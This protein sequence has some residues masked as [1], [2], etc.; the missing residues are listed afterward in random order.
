[1][2]AQRVAPAPPK[3]GGSRIMVSLGRTHAEIK[4]TSRQADR[5]PPGPPG[6]LP[7]ELTKPPR[8][9]GAPPGNANSILDRSAS[10]R[11]P[12][13]HPPKQKTLDRANTTRA[14][15][16]KASPP[17][18]LPMMKSASQS[19]GPPRQPAGAAVARQPTQTKQQQQQANGGATPRRRDK[20]KENEEVIRQLTAI[21]SPGDPNLVYRGLQK[22]GQ[23]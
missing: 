3:S 4:L 8:L 2:F 19:G 21:C 7:V 10:H 9:G 18:G 15:N 12:P 23:G 14:P 11:T 20:A 17:Q 22:I 16:S 13:T 1:M 5:P 6:R